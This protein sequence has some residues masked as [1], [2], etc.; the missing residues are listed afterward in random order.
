VVIW[1]VVVIMPVVLSGLVEWTLKNYTSH[2]RRS[3]LRIQSGCEW[4][5]ERAGNIDSVK[6]RTASQIAIAGLENQGRI[7]RRN[8]RREQCGRHERHSAV[9]PLFT[10]FTNC[11]SVTE[12]S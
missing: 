4:R 5:G 1:N 3:G 8:S 12:K 7:Q 9:V 10:I 11:G 6:V 2:Q